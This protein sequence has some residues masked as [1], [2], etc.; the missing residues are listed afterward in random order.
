MQSK[1]HLPDKSFPPPTLKTNG[2][3]KNPLFE[4]GIEFL[5][6]ILYFSYG[7]D[8]HRDPDS[9]ASNWNAKL[10]ACQPNTGTFVDITR[11]YR[12][13]TTVPA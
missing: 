4:F 3:C 12:D 9:D 10:V 8:Y 5:F 1:C 2:R 11:R 6:R 7:N 13:P